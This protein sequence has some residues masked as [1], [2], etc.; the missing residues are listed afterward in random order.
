MNIDLGIQSL[1]S[2][3]DS[4]SAIDTLLQ[5]SEFALIETVDIKIFRGRADPVPVVGLLTEQLPLLD[6]SGKL[7]VRIMDD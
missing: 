7:I 3:W 1:P 5:K 2:E 4:W 6:M